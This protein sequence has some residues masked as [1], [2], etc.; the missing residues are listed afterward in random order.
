MPGYRYFSELLDISDIELLRERYR[1]VRDGSRSLEGCIADCAQAAGLSFFEGYDLAEDIKSEVL[2]CQR[3]LALG[4]EALEAGSREEIAGLI[5]GALEGLSCDRPLFLRHAVLGLR[6]AGSGELRLEALSRGGMDYICS[7]ADEALGLEG[8]GEGALVELL[9]GELYALNLSLRQCRGLLHRLP[10]L[11][12]RIAGMVE[13]TSGNLELKCLAAA[14][15]LGRDS[16]LSLPEAAARVCTDLDLQCVGEALDSGA[17]SS[18]LAN[19]VCCAAG[20]AITLGAVAAMA[21]AAASG[22]PLL[23]LASL[24]LAPLAASLAAGA[25]AARGRLALRF[26]LARAG[27]GRGADEC[28]HGDV[29]ETARTL[30]S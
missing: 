26:A 4:R 7:H 19:L 15:L 27:K 24:L 8:L 2:A 12:D 3:R 18:A 10:R 13:L 28:G 14:C 1:A 23:A 5:R 30:V 17:L 16:E 22:V 6:A 21:A 29:I 11:D 9:A 20:V 25:F